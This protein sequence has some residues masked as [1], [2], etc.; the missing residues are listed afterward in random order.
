M[1]APLTANP[2]DAARTFTRE[3]GTGHAAQAAAREFEAIFLK[4]IM[5]TALQPMLH[6]TPESASLAGSMYTDMSSDILA[7]SMA[8]GPGIGLARMLLPHLQPPAASDTANNQP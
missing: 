3:A 5:S 1:L 4:Q 8:E 2:A 6:R 7:R